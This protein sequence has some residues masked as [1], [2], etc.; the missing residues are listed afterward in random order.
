MKR[1]LSV[2][3]ATLLFAGGMG[4]FGSCKNENESEKPVKEPYVA[5]RLENE[6]D[7]A[8]TF[9]VAEVGND[10]NEGT[11]DSPFKTLQKAKEEVKKINDSVDG[12]IA[13]VVRG[14]L[15]SQTSAL[16][17]DESDSGK[18]GNKI[19]YMGYP[20][21]DARI[22]GGVEV[23]NW[24]KQGKLY[25]TSI[26]ANYIRDLW[27]N[28]E[29]ATL[30][31]TPNGN[32]YTQ[33]VKW[34]KSA[35]KAICKHSDL[36]GA[37]SFEAVFYM[38][39]AEPVA[40]VE[41]VTVQGENAVMNFASSEDD[42]FFNRSYSE[43]PQLQSDMY[44]YFQNA[45]EFL[46]QPGEF[47]FSKEESRLY[48]YPREGENM[49]WAE[50]IVS[51]IDTVI[52]LDG[53]E[54]YAENLVFE[55]LSIEHNSDSTVSTY[56]FSE[57][58]SAHYIR[59]QSGMLVWDTLGAAIELERTRNV[60]FVNCRIR[61][62][63][64]GGII[65]WF[66]DYDCKIEGN[67]FEDIAAYA[68]TI[69][70]DSSYRA[71][72]SLYTPYDPSMICHDIEISDNY[73]VWT[74]VIYH[75]SAAIASMHGYNVSI[76][77]NEIGWVGYTGISC[78]WGWSLT[79]YNAK[80]NLIARNNI[81]HYGFYGSDLGGIYTLNNQP[82]TTIEENYI[83]ECAS[84]MMGF[85]S[86]ACAESIYLDEGSNNMT[87][88]NNQI[89]YAGRNRDLI[90]YHVAGDN[91]VEEGNKFLAQG[92]TLDETVVT[93]SGP[94]EEYR[95]NRP[96]V[97]SSGG[98]SAMTCGGKQVNADAGLYGYKA[99]CEKDM[100]VYG[101]GRFYIAGNNR[102]HRLS[103]YDSDKKPIAECTVDMSAGQVDR[104]G[105]KYAKF[106]KPLRLEKGKQ[107][108]FVS[109]EQADGD[110]YLFT[111]TS[112]YVDG[113]NVLGI[114]RGEKLTFIK[115]YGSAYVGINLL[116]SD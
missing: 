83:H 39:W 30:A 8:E 101:L 103:V 62:T 109:E 60:D 57:V 69:A 104:Y 16:E 9:Y 76:T 88:K 43:P 110:V 100:T 84:T 105:Y 3:T 89:A 24:K 85:S 51:N 72:G 59:R 2:F 63:G 58:Q 70:P 112:L 1:F 55:N 93:A 94:S 87:V 20:N 80:N 14:G 114:T 113:L 46:D 95:G 61:H 25:Y 115:N 35:K 38:E 66:S 40:R 12:D 31:R 81:H 34:D 68:V 17:F 13:V 91:I 33:L 37:T 71:N 5:K 75:R 29:R 44:V 108:Y 47:Y 56:G 53:G 90:C 111:N 32:E 97:L 22:S 74:S 79:E 82:G 28:G 77:N 65:F 41:S 49:S 78:G 67:V 45:M 64:S 10:E 86:V 92:D 15:Y 96:Y 36:S 21:E 27:V 19:V 11:W 48:Y 4:V 106:S 73:V 99:E 52:D 54:S 7:Y 23:G 42:I 26:S 116:T 107:Y 6:S 102:K 18:N 50:T 98:A